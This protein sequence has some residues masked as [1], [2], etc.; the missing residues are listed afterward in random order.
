MIK[1]VSL[2][3]YYHFLYQYIHRW[4]FGFESNAGLQPEPPFHDGD[5]NEKWIYRGLGSCFNQ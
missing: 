4:I 1:Y 5:G 3:V 2:S